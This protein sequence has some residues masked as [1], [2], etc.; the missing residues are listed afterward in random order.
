[1]LFLSLR[2]RWQYLFVV[3]RVFRLLI[4]YPWDAWKLLTFGS[5]M[6]QPN[7]STQCTKVVSPTIGSLVSPPKPKSGTPCQ[8]ILWH[9]TL[10]MQ[11]P[12]YKLPINGG[13]CP[14]TRSQTFYLPGR[15][16]LCPLHDPFPSSEH[17]MKEN[18]ASLPP[19]SLL[20]HLRHSLVS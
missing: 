13:Q 18:K 11:Y 9:G 20:M 3:Q 15:M 19:F 2:C 5:I 12:S 6:N 4:M 8:A 17:F 16:H 7:C 1:M 10:Y 14:H